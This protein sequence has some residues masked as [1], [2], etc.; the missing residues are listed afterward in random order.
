MAITS[1][2]P[3]LD[4]NPTSRPRMAGWGKTPVWR[5]QEN[6]HTTHTPRSGTNFNFSLLRCWSE[7]DGPQSHTKWGTCTD[8]LNLVVGGDR[9]NLPPRTNSY[10]LRVVLICHEVKFAGY[11]PMIWCTAFDEGCRGKSGDIGCG[12]PRRRMIQM[13]HLMCQ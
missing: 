10:I 2:G 4:G 9:N 12:S 6:P 13:G 5:G 11:G 7:N 1:G 3:T 8:E